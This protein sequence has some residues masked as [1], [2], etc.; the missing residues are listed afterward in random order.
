MFFFLFAQ[1]LQV[2]LVHETLPSTCQLLIC[3]LPFRVVDVLGYKPQELLNE[4]CYDYFHPDDL[5]HM[6]E[7]YQ[8]GKDCLGGVNKGL[9]GQANI[10]LCMHECRTDG[11]TRYCYPLYGWFLCLNVVCNILS[12]KSHWGLSNPSSNTDSE[13][14]L[15]CPIMPIS[16]LKG[17]CKQFLSVF[18]SQT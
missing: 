1:H 13:T 4:L 18:L 6:M 5:E 9:D 15:P 14:T 2:F 11:W 12:S 3:L 16:K 10:Y 17:I 8:Q 7:S